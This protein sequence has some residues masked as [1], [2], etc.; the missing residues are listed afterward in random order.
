MRQRFKGQAVTIA[1]CGFG[2]LIGIAALH[3]TARGD[4]QIT[5]FETFFENEL[6]ASWNAPEAFI[7]SGPTSYK[8]TATGY[9]SNYTFIG[10]L[11]ILGAGNTHIQLDVT[12]SSDLAAAD[13]HLGPI[14]TLVDGDNTRYSYRWYGQLLGHHILTRPMDTP[15]A[16]GNLGT[17]SGFDWDTLTHMHMELDP[18]SYGTMGAYTVEWNDLSLI[19]RVGVTGDFDDDGDVDGHDFLAWQRGESQTP[20]SPTDLADWQGAYGGGTLAATSSVP[21]PGTVCLMILMSASALGRLRP[22]RSMA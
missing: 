18:G 14:I 17:I 1:C 6:Y 2:V 4:V 9:G 3:G 22:I 16:I 8:V 5:G 15:D 21:E 13:G 11:G 10:A 20:F 7:E 19:T 12:L